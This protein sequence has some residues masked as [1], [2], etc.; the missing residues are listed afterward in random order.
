MVKFTLNEFRDLIISVLVFVL[1]IGI[2]L[3]DSMHGNYS[4][5]ITAALIGIVPG[6]V[7][8]ELAHKFMAI[9]Y[10]FDAE[11]K[12]SVPGLFVALASSF[13]GLMIAAPGA[14]HVKGER[15]ITDEESG[16]IAIVG[17]IVN[18][19]LA[20]IFSALVFMTLITAI[21]NSFNGSFNSFLNTHG[22]DLFYIGI[23][24][25]MINATMAAL[26]ML[27]GGVFDGSKVFDWNKYIWGFVAIISFALGLLAIL[28]M[29]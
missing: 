17:P 4:L 10:G 16:K 3:R 19:I 26:N 21:L 25:F 6:F 8:H 29:F 14:V 18:I 27:P 22:N 15:E 1:A 12:M 13:F 24:G 28:L 2:L 5:L 20:L 23:V 11:F 9:K 7:F